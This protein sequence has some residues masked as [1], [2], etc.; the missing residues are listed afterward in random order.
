MRSLIVTACFMFAFSF[1]LVSCKEDSTTEPEVRIENCGDGQGYK[2]VF[3]KQVDHYEAGYGVAGQDV[4]IVSCLVGPQGATV[5]NSMNGTYYCSGTY[6][7]STFQ[8][9]KIDLNWG[10]TTSYSMRESFSITAKGTGTFKVKCTKTSGG[11]GNMFLSMAS[12]SSWM[13]NTVLVNE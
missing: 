4:I 2:V 3:T 1:M 5:S 7:L 8:T 11:S 12:G 13:F 10:G 9:A 6:T